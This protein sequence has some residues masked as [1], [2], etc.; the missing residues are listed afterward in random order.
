MPYELCRSRKA[1]LL[2]EPISLSLGFRG[3]GFRPV[4]RWDSQVLRIINAV[5]SHS[6]VWDLASLASA[7]RDLAVM[8]CAKVARTLRK[9][10]S[11][12]DDSQTIFNVHP[13]PTQRGRPVLLPLLRLLVLQ[14]EQGSEDLDCK[15]RFISLV[16]KHI[17][18]KPPYG[19]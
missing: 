7:L 4:C 3:L 10:C 11:L 2:Y 19:G 12:Q 6:S 5:G 1:L 13:P 18:D 8:T 17:F 14:G 16:A 9:R 15:Q